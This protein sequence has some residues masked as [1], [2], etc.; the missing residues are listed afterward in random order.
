M[1]FLALSI[2]LQWSKEVCPQSNQWIKFN[3]N[4]INVN[5]LDTLETNTDDT[6][7]QKMTRSKS[8]Y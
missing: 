5:W 2:L 7:M 4:T 3:V 6:E 8:E 1:M